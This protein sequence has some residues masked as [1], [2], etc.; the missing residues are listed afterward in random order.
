MMRI[1][2]L[3]FRAIPGLAACCVALTT[4]AQ[5]FDLKRGDIQSFATRVE[6]EYGVPR[7]DVLKVLADA[8]RKDSILKAI[9]RPAEKSKP[10]HEYRQIFLNQK[11]VEGGQ[12]FWRQHA[13]SLERVSTQ[14]GVPIEIIVAIIGI[15]T[16]YGRITGSYRVLDAL[17]TLA[18][19]YPKRSEFFTRELE[20]FFVLTR[21]ENVDVLK[22][23]GS[24]AGAM[25]AGQFMP[26]SYRLYAVDGDTNG[27]RDLWGSW[28]DVFASI[29]N[30]FLAHGWQR[31]QPTAAMA[32]ADRETARNLASKILTPAYRLGFLRDQGVQFK[33]SLN[34]N[35]IGTLIPFEQPDGDEHLVGFHNFF[36]ITRYNRSRLYARSVMELG[37]EIAAGVATGD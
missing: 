13:R 6:A 5:G 18:F 3:F 9:S 4:Q 11:R 8:Q 36:V 21:E 7:A 19:D 22:V 31:D 23:K 1:K 10:W 16:N 14:T 17:S 2:S 34:D 24:Y 37:N 35:D 32:K 33:T 29:A 26:S 27:Q 25:G 28:D 15:E 30:Y 12:A 20:H